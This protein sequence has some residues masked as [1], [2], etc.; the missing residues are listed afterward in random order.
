M[1]KRL[2]VII[3]ILLIIIAITSVIVLGKINTKELNKEAPEKA[4]PTDVQGDSVI[5]VSLS[6]D[7][8][9]IY[10]NKTT[11]AYATLHYSPSGDTLGYT[12]RWHCSGDISCPERGGQSVIIT[13]N[14]IGHGLVEVEVT[15]NGNTFVSNAGVTVMAPT[16]RV[17]P[18]GDQMYVGDQL[19][20]DAVTTPSGYDYYWVSSNPRTATINNNGVITA[21]EPGT[22]EIYAKFADPEI[23]GQSNVT[24]VTVNPPEITGVEEHPHIVIGEEIQFTPIINPSRFHLDHCTSGN[25]A[26]VATLDSATCKFKGI[27]TG[28]SYITIYTTG[29]GQKQITV[30]VDPPSAT[31]LTLSKSDFYTLVGKQT[32]ITATLT[33][34]GSTG[35]VEWSSSDSSVAEYANGKITAKKVGVANIKAQIA[36][37]T[38]SKTVKVNVIDPSSLGISLNKQSTS[39]YINDTET[40]TATVTPQG[41]PGTIDW[42]SSNTSVATVSS[43]G[44]ITAKAQG[45]TTI[46]AKIELDGTIKRATCTV[47]VID[48]SQ[49]QILLNKSALQLLVGKTETLTARLEPE[50]ATGTIT[51]S[52]NKES[53]ATVNQNGKVTAVAKGTATITATLSGTDKKATCTVTVFDP[54]DLSVTVNKTTANLNVG[55][56][57]TI[58]A[59]ISPSEYNGTVTWSSSNESIASVSNGKI[60]AVKAGTATITATIAGTD[61]KA[62]VAVTVTAPVPATSITLSDLSITLKKGETKKITYTIAPENSTDT[63]VEWAS[64]DTSIATVAQDGTITAVK[65]GTAN[66]TATVKG[67]TVKAT[68]VVKV[69]DP[70]TEII[71]IEKVTLK[72]GK[73]KIKV[74]EQTSVSYTVTPTN[75]TNQNLEIISSDDAIAKVSGS[76]IVGVKVGKAK[77]MVISDE[78][79]VLAEV[80]IQVVK[81]S[82]SSGNPETGATLSIITVLILAVIGYYLFT[83]SDKYRTLHKV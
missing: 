11:R 73:T 39:L 27:T 5:G 46:T 12:I 6:V 30:T 71:P 18:T 76:N 2:K 55:G 28:N 4:N 45:T 53:V 32:A 50:N 78:G 65:A 24:V 15:S 64:S 3:P 66:I 7:E 58:T 51:W 20:Y 1:K 36:G 72:L 56:T 61:K 26:V 13:G 77:I 52:S 62:T 49:I 47:T 14:N 74:K 25:G 9:S 8:S 68:L 29:G 19:Q 42:D 31:G 34:S 48:P 59:T 69:T 43:A 23:N 79:E 37:T 63:E 54:A 83:H 10:L 41:F 60:T 81:N 80:S 38:I 21:E 67:R 57:E 70:A 40:L 16:I 35:I 22:T 82:G 44:K 33:P 17:Y 75:A